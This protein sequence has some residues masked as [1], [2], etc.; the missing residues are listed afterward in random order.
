MS[1]IGTLGER[2]LHAALKW[3]YEPTEDFHEIPVGRFIADIKH[4][5]K[6]TEIQTQ[7]FDRL[8]RKLEV[9][10]EEFEV[11]VVCPVAHV[12]HL[13]WVDE[14]TGALIKRRKSPKR[15][16]C[17]DALW[18]LYKIKQ[19]LF[20]PNLKLRIILLEVT[21]RRSETSKNRKGYSR[22]DTFPQSVSDEMTLDCASDF[23]KLVPATLC[24]EFTSQEYAKAAGIQQKYAWTALNVLQ[25]VGVLEHVGKRGRSNLYSLAEYIK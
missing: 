1:G 4:G 23:V 7:G 25:Y 6:I 20:S 16:S 5:N 18:E 12:K 24:D 15:G 14:A 11:T 19:F 2:S 22:L 21:E 9:F 3:Y 17:Y 13:E 8:R 10:L